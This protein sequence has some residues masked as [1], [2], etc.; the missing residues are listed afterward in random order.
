M[1][2]ALNG[3]LKGPVGFDDLKKN[4]APFVSR[5]RMTIG[6]AAP[7]HCFDGSFGISDIGEG[8]TVHQSLIDPETEF[9]TSFIA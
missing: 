1:R 8:Q 7:L 2:N 9:E 5:H 3:V 4:S 6:K